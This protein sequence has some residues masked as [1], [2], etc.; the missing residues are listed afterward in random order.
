[1][2]YYESVLGLLVCAGRDS[3]VK[4]NNNITLLFG[5]III[6]INFIIVWNRQKE[7][8]FIFE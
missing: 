3:I 8:W 6:I 7:R 2:L 5:I 1:M 4:A